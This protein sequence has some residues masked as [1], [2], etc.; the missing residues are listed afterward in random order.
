MNEKIKILA[1]SWRDIKAPK[2]GG[3]EVH[4]HM[5]L[6]GLD[7]EQYEVVHISPEYEGCTK[8][9]VIDGV[10]YI[11]MGNIFTVIWKAFRYIEDTGMS[12]DG[13]LISV[14]RIVFLRGCMFRRR[15]ECS[16]FISL[17]GRYGNTI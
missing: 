11:R 4:T 15:R 7:R 14:I 6:S 2:A 13:S 1:L 17:P 12:I 3:A 8:K 9:E 16:I 10:A 5:M